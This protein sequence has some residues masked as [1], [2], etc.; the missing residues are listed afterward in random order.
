M[1]KVLLNNLNALYFFQ[2]LIQN[3]WLVFI[4]I[5]W[6]GFLTVHLINVFGIP[7]KIN[8][9]SQLRI[10]WCYFYSLCSQHVSAPTGHPWVKYNYINYIFWK[11]HRYYNG[12]VVLQVLTTRH[13]TI[14]ITHWDVTTKIKF[15]IYI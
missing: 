15:D 8:L 12:S 10:Y 3:F 6:Y 4:L 11:S 13:N 7:F 5:H 1:L 9:R 14:I 2:H